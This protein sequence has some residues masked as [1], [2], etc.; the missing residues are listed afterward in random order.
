MR[1]KTVFIIAVVILLL[2]Y[3]FWSVYDAKTRVNQLYQQIPIS[4]SAEDVETIS[5]KLDLKII[6][7]AEKDSRTMKMMVWDGW[8]FARWSC[9]VTCENNK[10]VGKKIVFID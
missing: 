4:A 8:A 1:K 6:R 7:S 9:V 5:R 2:G 3:P 10:V